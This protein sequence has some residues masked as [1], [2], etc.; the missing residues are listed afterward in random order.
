[1]VKLSV[2][3]LKV[4]DEFW[5]TSPD[6]TNEYFR[7]EKINYLAQIIYLKHM[8]FS[9]KVWEEPFKQLNFHLDYGC[10]V[11]LNR[12]RTNFTRKLGVRYAR[13]NI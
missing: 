8:N 7:V 9:H 12:T 4:G 3:K 1:M 6:Y 5:F 11:R 10:A 2:D 13:T